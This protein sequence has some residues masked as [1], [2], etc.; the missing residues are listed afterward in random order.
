MICIGSVSLKYSS[1]ILKAGKMTNVDKTLL[2]N[3]IDATGAKLATQAELEAEVKNGL[4][5]CTAGI[6]ATPNGY[7][8]GWP[9]FVDKDFQGPSC[10]ATPD[11]ACSPTC[12]SKAGCVCG[13]GCNKKFNVSAFNKVDVKGFWLKGN[14]PARLTGSFSDWKVA[15]YSPKPIRTWRRYWK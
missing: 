3:L 11:T 1:H 6:A 14:K 12:D 5:F 8:V 2:A 4:N 13:C 15:P 10:P 9:T 7:V